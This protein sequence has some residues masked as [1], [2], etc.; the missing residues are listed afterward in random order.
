MKRDE[1][2]KELAAFFSIN[3][4]VCT[5]VYNKWGDRA[6]QFLATDYLHT[7]LIVR[8]DIL[9]TG[10][11]CN[12]GAFTQRGLRCNLCELVATKTT[13]YLSSHILGQAG[14]FTVDALSAEQARAKIREKAELLPCNI[15]MED[16]VSWLHIDTLQ[17][18]GVQVKVYEFK[19]S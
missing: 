18:V 4:L 9:C 1:I 17:Q 8:R 11:I 16:G 19:E 14:D 2:I 15:R 5:H 7:L 6:W 3:E 13:P 10:M 12:G